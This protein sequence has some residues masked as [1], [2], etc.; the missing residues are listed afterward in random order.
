ML[1]MKV[2]FRPSVI[3]NSAFQSLDISHRGN[4][5]PRGKLGTFIPTI[6]QFDSL[7]EFKLQWNYTNRKCVDMLIEALDWHAG[8]RK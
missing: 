3:R 7:K 1:I 6:G 2:F 8:L 4:S 5:L